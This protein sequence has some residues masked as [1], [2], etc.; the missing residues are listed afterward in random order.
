MRGMMKPGA[1]TNCEPV[2]RR[3]FLAVGASALG[4]L[5]LVD[6]TLVHA[7]TDVSLGSAAKAVTFIDLLRMPDDVAAYGSFAK[8]LPQE[9]MQLERKAGNWVSSQIEVACEV[10]Q[11]S[12][13]FTLS[14]PATAVAVVQVRWQTKVDPNMRVLGDAWERSYGDLGW[15]NL[16]PERVLPWYFATYDGRTCHGYGVKTDARALCFWQVDAHGVSLWMNTCNGGEGV[17]PGERR[18][19]MATVVSRRGHAEEAA[20]DAVTGLCKAMCARPSRPLQPIYGANDWNYSYGNSTAETILRDTEFIAELSPTTGPRPFS[21]IDG[22]WENKTRAWPDMGRLAAGIRQR[23]ARP[24][25]WIR[26]LEAP[27]TAASRLMIPDAR[28]GGKKDRTVELAYDPTVPEAQEKIRAKVREVAGWGYEMVKHDFSTYDLLGQWG[29]EMG[30][31]PALPGWAL[32]DRSRTNAEVITDLYALI[33]ETAGES[34]VIDGCNTIGHLGQGFFDMQRTGDDTSGRQWERTRRMGINTAAFRLPQHGTFFC[35]DADLVGITEAIPWELNRQW[36]D[37]LARSGTST[38]I[39]AGAPAHGQ[40]Q[41]DAIREAFKI[42]AAGGLEAK[43]VDWMETSAPA[44]WRSRA[45][46][47]GSSEQLY[48]WDGVSGASAYLGS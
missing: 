17:L 37:M 3:S 13:R 46:T 40:E 39:A 9:R 16:M 41:R 15:R 14:A 11:N 28:F 24:G 29:F 48:D 19:T 1:E 30:P 36:L 33:R 27:E 21:V 47:R 26:P 18:L 38:M 6:A 44:R 2:S 12:V 34:V 23:S 4:S 43:P 42:A 7:A 32:H 35:L 10:G 31:L 25:I 45:E 22:G 8:T 20:V 5:S